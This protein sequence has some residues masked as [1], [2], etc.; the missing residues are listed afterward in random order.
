MYVHV[1]ALSA[2]PCCFVS[3]G[4]SPIRDTFWWGATECS[5][6]VSLFTESSQILSGGLEDGEKLGCRAACREG[7]RVR[8]H[9]QTSDSSMGASSL[10]NMETC[11]LPPCQLPSCLSFTP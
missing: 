5:M 9:A 8:L 7:S 6:F 4:N 10:C 2:H 3:C 1:K 11:V